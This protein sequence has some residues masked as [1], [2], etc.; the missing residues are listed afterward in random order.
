MEEL[1]LPGPN[2]FI[3]TRLEVDK[4]LVDEPVKRPHLIRKTALSSLWHKKD[5][6]FWVPKAHVIVDIRRYV[7]DLSA[8]EVLTSLEAPL[9][10]HL[11]VLL[12]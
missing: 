4:R 6:Q 12:S 8:N 9:P 1:S 10:I 11:Q 3:P 5:D 2:E 7:C